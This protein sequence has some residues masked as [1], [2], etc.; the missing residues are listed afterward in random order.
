MEDLKPALATAVQERGSGRFDPGREPGRI[1][2]LPICTEDLTG[3]KTDRDNHTPAVSTTLQVNTDYT[4][5]V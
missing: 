4:A 5:S 3:I 1:R 2:M